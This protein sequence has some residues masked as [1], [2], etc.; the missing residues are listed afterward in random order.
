[1]VAETPDELARLHA[2]I[3]TERELGLTSEVLQGRE[4]ADLA[5]ALAT[6]L[7]G[8][9]FCPEEG[10]VNPLLATGAFASAACGHGADIR[11]GCEVRA[12]DAT[13]SGGFIVHTK[14]GPLRASRVV[15]AAGAWAGRLP[16]S[17][18]CPSR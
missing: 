15:N 8:A 13:G 5:P 10:L 11:T 3:K 18:G 1:M 7:A 17:P 16:G 12:V 14:A 4:L 2:K 6:D 9:T